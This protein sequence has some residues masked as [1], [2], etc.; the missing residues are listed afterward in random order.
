MVIRCWT[1]MV[2]DASTQPAQLGASAMGTIKLV[3][4]SL[5]SSRS[6]GRRIIGEDRL[7]RSQEPVARGVLECVK[8]VG[9]NRSCRPETT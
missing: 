5:T 6:P 8:T 2:H 3:V 7:A 9:L 1:V 4:R